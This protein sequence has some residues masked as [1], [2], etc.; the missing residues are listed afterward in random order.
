VVWKVLNSPRTNEDTLRKGKFQSSRIIGTSPGQLT[1]ER[2]GPDA[3]LG[4]FDSYISEFIIS[5]N[6]W[7]HVWLPGMLGWEAMPHGGR[8]C[9]MLMQSGSVSALLGTQFSAGIIWDGI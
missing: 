3:E 1:K 8:T 6:P 4:T 7:R 5:A 2:P 9:E